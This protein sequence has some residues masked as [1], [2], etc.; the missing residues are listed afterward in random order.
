[1][2]LQQENEKYRNNFVYSFNTFLLLIPILLCVFVGF[3]I[4]NNINSANKTDADNTAFYD[5]D[6]VSLEAPKEKP[7]T[8]E[9]VLK[10]L[11][12]ESNVGIVYTDSELLNCGV[13]AFLEKYPN[14]A[15]VGGCFRPETPDKI[16]LTTNLP[17]L[18]NET[19]RY[20][21]THEYAHYLQFTN[22]EPLSE[23]AAEE[24]V[25]QN[26]V[27]SPQSLYANQCSAN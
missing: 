9:E 21:V 12:P 8:P 19:I 11:N 13:T 2:S 24:F 23:C 22:N 27:S 26:G 1:M 7:V 16:Y 4:F 6:E 10:E 15:P 3:S 20:L 17:Q 25:A 18:R 14:D 5:T